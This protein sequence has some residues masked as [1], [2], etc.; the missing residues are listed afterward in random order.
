[1]KCKRCGA[2]LESG[3]RFCPACG[4]L[5]PMICPQC[6]AESRP[7]S[8]D[9]SVCGKKLPLVDREDKL[10]YTKRKKHT[11]AIIVT[12][13]GV[14][15]ALLLLG[16]AVM[17]LIDNLDFDKQANI[18]APEQEQTPE[19]EGQP[20]ISIQ[21]EVQQPEPEQ[22][23][24]AEKD[25]PVEEEEP[26]VEEEEPPVEEEEP[27]VEE[28]EPPVEEEEPPVEEEEPPVEDKYVDSEW[29][30][31]DSSERLLTNADIAGLSA[32]ELK[33]ARN[34]IYARHGRRFNSAELQA[35]FDGCDWYNGTIAPGD[36]TDSMLSDT[37]L[38][39]VQFLKAAE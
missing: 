12:A 1:M 33:V 34:E 38:A 22:E 32:W 15:C 26:P 36:F 25:P 29:I 3:A 30:F 4:A 35:H 9:C 16:G 8:R 20:A 24:P 23:P 13:V 39:N 14:L 37:E 7:G 10:V 18:S 2:E 5:Q 27:P 11:G 17:L 28:E 31:A 19:P 6:G 21:P